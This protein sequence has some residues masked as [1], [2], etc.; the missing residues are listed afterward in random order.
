MADQKISH[1]ETRCIFKAKSPVFMC[2]GKPFAYFQLSESVREYCFEKH[3]STLCSIDNSISKGLDNKA[4]LPKIRIWRIDYRKCV[5]VHFAQ[6]YIHYRHVE[7]L[8]QLG[9]T[10]CAYKR[11]KISF[12]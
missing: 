5:I 11:G 6:K 2:S 8:P 1:D 4:I 12:L 3:C 9:I 7:A 10:Q